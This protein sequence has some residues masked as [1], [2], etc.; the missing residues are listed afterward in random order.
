MN[1]E[2]ECISDFYSQLTKGKIYDVVYDCAD[3]I[4]VENDLGY[5]KKYPLDTFRFVRNIEVTKDKIT[6]S[7]YGKQFDVIDFCQK[8]NLD[9]MQGNVIKYVTRYK[10]KN[11]IEDLEKAKEY[12]DRLIK[13]EKRSE[14]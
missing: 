14:N 10:K 6:P 3:C 12:I 2:V 13:F 8:N 9:F 4:V 5:R 1:K 7:Y 11:G